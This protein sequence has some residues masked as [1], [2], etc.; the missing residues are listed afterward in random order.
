MGIWAWLR[1][2]GQRYAV[3]LVLAGGIMGAVVLASPGAAGAVTDEMRRALCTV[4]GGT[5][6][7]PPEEAAVLGGTERENCSEW[8]GAEE[9]PPARAD[10]SR[11]ERQRI[12]TFNIYGSLGHAG[13]AE[14]IVSTVVDSV[15]QRTPV[16]LGLQEVCETQSFA[17]AARLAPYGYNVYFDPTPKDS[18]DSGEYATCKNGARF[19]NAIVYRADFADDIAKSSHDL[20][21]PDGQSTKRRA[22]CVS[23]E[24]KGAVFCTAHLTAKSE[25]DDR[26]AERRAEAAALKDV[27]AEKYQG[28]TVLLGGDLNDEPVS[29]ALDDFYDPRYGAGADG[30]LKEADSVGQGSGRNGGCRDGA[31]TLR[32]I[33]ERS[34][35]AVEVTKFKLDYLF[36]SNDVEIHGTEVDE[37]RVSDHNSLWSDVTF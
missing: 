4:F 7:A 16:F 12:G 25:K 10:G 23:S 32:V 17:L 24:S 35:V 28:M 1:R 15:K 21:T 2:C 13:D 9:A 33:E 11:R 8:A 30:D 26:E 19:G 18:Y 37:D 20:N 5:Y 22:P 6:C 27:L 3:P 31:L 29:A 36:V 34:G 14:P